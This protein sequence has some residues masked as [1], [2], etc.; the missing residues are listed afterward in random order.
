MHARA[1][2]IEGSRDRLED[3]IARLEH[4]TF[5]ELQHIDGFSGIL[6]LVDRETSRTLVVT[7]WE[8]EAA[9]LESEATAN[10]LRRA[11]ADELGTRREPK[12]D[13]YECVLCEVR[14]PVHA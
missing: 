7:L 9:M 11:A 4:D 5:E 12:V 3:G 14:T 6:G 1:S 8:S 2:M 13:R 10:T